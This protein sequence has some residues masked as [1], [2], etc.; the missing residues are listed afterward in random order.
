MN[1]K[2]LSTLAVCAITFGVILI[3]P[4]TTFAKSGPTGVNEVRTEAGPG[5]GEVT[6]NWKRVSPDVTNYGIMYGTE[7][8]KYT[9]GADKIG[10]SVSFTVKGLTP[11]TKY[12]FMIYPYLKDVRS[13]SLS[14]EISE[15]AAAS[16]RTVVGTSGPYGRNLLSAVS[17]PNKG[18]VTLNWKRFHPDTDAYTIV[19][20]PKP[21]MYLWGVVNAKDASNPNDSDF[22]FNI[23]NLNPGGRY[24]FAIIPQ[25]QGSGRY[26]SAEVSQ[27][28]K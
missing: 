23:G 27:V 10:N 7:S 24:Y 26:I 15:T 21:G 12:Y 22:S 2:L 11:G 19:Y 18:Q 5:T 13:A 6:L 9:F 20:G 4:V 3:A 25:V 17:G 1:T 8:G 14:P 16:A 28:A